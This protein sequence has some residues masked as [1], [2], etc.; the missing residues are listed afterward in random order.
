[1]SSKSKGEQKG[2]IISKIHNPKFAFRY[3]TICLLLEPIDPEV[4]GPEIEPKHNI[5]KYA[6]I[7]I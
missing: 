6:N 3:K 7:F 5:K 1:M 2:K 4:D